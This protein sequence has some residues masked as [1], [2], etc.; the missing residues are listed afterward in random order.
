MLF[1]KGS[2]VQF[3]IADNMVEY[4]LKVIIMSPAFRRIDE[5]KL[6]FIF[7]NGEGCSIDDIPPSI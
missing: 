6:R 3:G 2:I 4:C 1:S 5:L 7:Q